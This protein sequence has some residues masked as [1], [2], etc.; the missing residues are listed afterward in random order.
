MA[1]RSR[2]RSWPWATARTSCRSRPRF[3]R[4]LA[5]LK[6]TRSS[7]RSLSDCRTSCHALAISPHQPGVVD[8][9][10]PYNQL[11]PRPLPREPGKREG[12]AV[13]VLEPSNLI[14][15]GGCPDS[16]RSL[17]HAL[18]PDEVYSP[19]AKSFNR[20]AHF[21]HPPACNRKRLRPKA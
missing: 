4:R 15:P 16:L 7:L 2:V 8:Q 18:L 3:G 6:E 10:P 21:G 5:R 19:V 12:V 14:P 1:N 17:I 20:L 13:G 11:R 9:A